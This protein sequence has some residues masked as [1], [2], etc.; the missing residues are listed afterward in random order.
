MLC[1]IFL[2]D[3]DILVIERIASYGMPV[4]ETVFETVF[5][6][7]RFVEHAEG[8]R[9]QWDRITRKE[10]KLHLCNSL[11]ANDAAVIQALK[12]RF[13]EKGTKKNPGLLYGIKGDEWQ[14][15]AVAVAY[16]EGVRHEEKK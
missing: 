10:I 15:L 11:R 6:T 14:A 9:R 8:G 5:W 2:Q 16:A 3:A 12:D 7:G 4:S 1:L 13:G